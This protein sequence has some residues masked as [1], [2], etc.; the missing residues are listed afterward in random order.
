[1]LLE[2]DGRPT[3]D[4]SKPKSAV[5]END[6]RW[7]VTPALFELHPTMIEQQRSDVDSPRV[8]LNE[9]ADHWDATQELPTDETWETVDEHSTTL[10][11][12][13][14]DM[15]QAYTDETMLTRSESELWCLRKFVGD[16][17]AMLTFEAVALVLAAPD[18]PFTAAAGE[19]SSLTPEAVEQNIGRVAATVEPAR[20]VAK[21]EVEPTSVNWET[22]PVLCV[23]DR[24]TRTRLRNAAQADE[25]TENDVVARLLDETETRLGLQEFCQ[26]YL[27]ERGRDS[28]AQL[29]VHSRSLR[30]D[31]IHITAHTGLSGDVPSVVNETDAIIVAGR[32]FDFQLTEDPWG[33]TTH[34]RIALYGW[35][36]E[37]DSEV[38]LDDGVEAVREQVRQLAERDD[39]P[40]PG[41]L[42]T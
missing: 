42:E 1:M 34:Q 19:I 25:Q 15:I 17:H 14:E 7:S 33:P 3:H 12:Q 24:S 27:D 8:Q 20:Q 35:T 36:D 9:L 6:D 32:R 18:T 28:V 26:E 29:V 13:L 31:S 41:T 30:G 40:G 10:Y 23:L 16:D 5:P 22:S 11:T 2:H 37:H 39:V 21:I 38:A 4:A